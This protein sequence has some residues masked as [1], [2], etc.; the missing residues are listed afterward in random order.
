MAKT[1]KLNAEVIKHTSKNGYTYSVIAFTDIH[2]RAIYEIYDRKLSHRL[3]K[4]YPELY[5][6]NGKADDDSI[7]LP[8]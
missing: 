3:R 2:G 7:D 6:V 5:E 4:Y 8:F 1:Y